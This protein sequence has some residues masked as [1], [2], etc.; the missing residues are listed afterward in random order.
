M[1]HSTN[2]LRWAIVPVALRIVGVLTLCVAALSFLAFH[3]TPHARATGQSTKITGT[4][5]SSPSSGPVGTTISVSG[6]G[7]GGTDGTS[8][9]FGYQVDA[10]CHIVSDA[11]N[12]TLSGGSFSGW[13]RWPSGTALNTFR[14]CVMLG[15]VMEIA[16]SFSVLSSSPP[17]VSISP[18][19]LA[20]NTHATITASNYYPAGTAVNFLWMSGNTV[21]ENLNS[22][23]SNSNGVAILTFTVPKF[24]I[25]NGRY[26]ISAS[27]GTGQPAT[28]FSSTNFTYAAPVIS[29]SPTVRPSPTPS[30]ALTPSVT[31]TTTPTVAP[32]ATA[33]V[34]ATNASPTAGTSPTVGSGQTP[35]TNGTNSGNNGGTNTGAD[36]SSSQGN[37]LLIGGVIVLAGAL[38]AGI[39]A[40]LLLSRRRKAARAKAKGMPPRLPDNPNPLSYP[41]YNPAAGPGMAAPQ[42]VN[43]P[44]MPLTP[45][46]V[47]VG[48]GAFA[49]NS[50]PAAP[51]PYSG[52]DTMP[53]IPRSPQL[54][55]WPNN[56]SSNAGAPAGGGN[57]PPSMSVAADPALDAMRRQ[58]QSGLFV[59]PR[60][61]RDERS[62]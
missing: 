52:P 61:F 31:P 37:A 60:P 38:L 30:P 51:A 23:A 24:S 20:P 33:S 34:T 42:L 15:N 40:L 27:S 3:P 9:S 8:V 22:A 49:G 59:S 44:A 12:G 19:T 39:A 4:L 16:G 21:V 11:Q 54:P 58:A 45:A 13:F 47:P 5:S 29:P 32:S 28:L 48:A 46:P 41:L 35:T 26:S 36:T 14:V 6:S 55:T 50:N 43:M 62:L 25:A 53:P 18:A 2:R 10:G 56:S 7:W 17:A 57:A 1:Q